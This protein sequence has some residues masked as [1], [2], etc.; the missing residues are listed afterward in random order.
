M[1]FGLHY[2]L[3]VS[4]LWPRDK[5]QERFISVTELYGI[6]KHCVISA[7]VHGKNACKKVKC[8]RSK[9]PSYPTS[10]AKD[11]VDK[12]LLPMC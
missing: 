12:E 6:C 8:F 1:T 3:V 7:A 5:H 2:I 11:S 4:T 10:L 9:P